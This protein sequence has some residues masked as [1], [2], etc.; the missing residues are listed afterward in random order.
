[1]GYDCYTVEKEEYFRANIWG[2]KFLRKMMKL[3]GVDFDTEETRYCKPEED[4]EGNV[5]QH[6]QVG[7]LYLCFCSNDGW[8]VTPENCRH[9]AEKLQN[10]TLPLDEDHP[11]RD[12]LAWITDE[13]EKQRILALPRK[14]IT[15]DDREFVNN[16]I[17]FCV[18]AADQGGFY[19]W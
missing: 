12:M 4:D 2:M 8:H 18:K 16:F 10:F 9:I 19:V 14:P 3:A 13:K 6:S 7:S 15:D 1:M 17:E 5:C 11:E